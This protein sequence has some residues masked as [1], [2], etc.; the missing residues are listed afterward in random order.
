M[1]PVCNLS[2][3]FSNCHLEIR[4][5]PCWGWIVDEPKT[6]KTKG[7]PPRIGFLPSNT[8]LL[9]TKSCSWKLKIGDEI[10]KKMSWTYLI[11]LICLI[12][13]LGHLILFYSL[14]SSFWGKKFRNTV[15]VGDK[16]LCDKEL[17]DKEQLGVMEPFPVTNL[18]IFFIRIRN[19]WC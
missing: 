7:I 18:S 17:C 4:A 19:I 16:E 11:S 9:L 13:S 1:S 15:K 6:G 3:A 10:M 2:G 8:D 14:A 12:L 5:K